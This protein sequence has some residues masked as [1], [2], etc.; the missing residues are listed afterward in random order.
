[1]AAMS[2]TRGAAGDTPDRSDG[3]AAPHPKVRLAAE[4]RDLRS[5]TG[6]SLRDLQ[7]HTH[8]SDS[9][10]SRY[11]SG[12][13]IPPWAVVEA[14]CALADRPAARLRPLWELA[15]TT[16]TQ[17]GRN[18]LPAAPHAVVGRGPQFAAMTGAPGVWVVDGMAGVGKTALSLAVAHRLAPDFPDAQLYVD[19]HGYTSG[20]QRLEP[21]TALETL[22]RA[23]G[24]APSQIPENLDDRVALWRA[25]IAARRALVVVDNAADEAHI[26][27]LLPGTQKTAMIVTSR[28][29]LL[30]LDGVRSLSLDVLEPADAVEMFVR[31]VGADRM[32]GQE[33]GCAAVVQL[34]GFLPLAVRICAARLQHRPTW[35]AEHLASR[36]RQEGRRLAE[37]ESGD[38]GVAGALAVSVSQ[39]D[40]PLVRAF[41]LLGTGPGA[42]LDAYAASALFS[43]SPADAEDL[44]E[45]LLDVRLLEQPAYGRYRMHD[46]V[47]DHAR[48]HPVPDRDEARA[49]LLDFYLEC[50]QTAMPLVDPAAAPPR[51]DVGIRPAHT[52]ELADAQQAAAWLDR[53]VGEVVEAAREAHTAGLSV[54]VISLARAVNRYFLLQG[55]TSEWIAMSGLALAAAEAGGRVEDQAWALL[56]SGAATRRSGEAHAALEY[57]SRARDLATAHGGVEVF[58]FILNALAAVQAD[59]RRLDEAGQTL[60]QAIEYSDAAGDARGSG[61]S[62]ANLAG[63]L[64]MQGDLEP[65]ANLAREALAVLANEDNRLAA[66]NAYIVLGEVHEQSGAAAEAHEHYIAARDLTREGGIRELEAVALNGLARV[67]CQLG[68]PVLA[69]EYHAQVAA[70]VEITGGH[71]KVA[72]FLNDR[73]VTRLCAGQVEEALQDNRDALAVAREYGNQFEEKRALNALGQHGVV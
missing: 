38:R 33:D 20:R 60:R 58:G 19:L 50:A 37:L 69:L 5:A 6:M 40:P 49:R 8:S 16:Q 57:L 71:Q 15:T 56:A 41:A 35:S 12:R 59:L 68:D 64:M 36:L 42:G 47:R 13:I 29:K 54:S 21:E 66:S 11:L 24:S 9:S 26:R 65:A 32:S 31:L 63:L 4:L 10:L 1:M 73:A 28:R 2:R 34:C 53:H 3:T 67:T 48:Q 39:L 14:L 27:P 22:L 7:R 43:S 72:A 55:H 61:G 62:R 23:L 44:M 30:G 45:E 46:L 51:R 17:L 18:D 70:L 52:P 25:E